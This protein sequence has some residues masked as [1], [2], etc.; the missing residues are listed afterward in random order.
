MAVEGGYVQMRCDRF[1]IKVT[2]SAGRMVD[3]LVALSD[4]L[5]LL[6]AECM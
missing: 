3:F 2:R 1:G 5:G 6:Q 4:F